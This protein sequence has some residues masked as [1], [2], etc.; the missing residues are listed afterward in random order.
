MCADV[1][2]SS[3]AETLCQADAK[4]CYS[5]DPRARLF[6]RYEPRVADLRGAMW[7]LGHNDFQGADAD[8]S[9]LDR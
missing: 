5:S 2:L 4:N 1:A 6:R 8:L 7:L 9:A 3:G